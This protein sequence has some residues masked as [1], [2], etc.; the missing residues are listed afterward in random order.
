MKS[1]SS[2]DVAK[3][4]VRVSMTSSRQEEEQLIKDLNRQGIQVTAVDIGGNLI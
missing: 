2:L 1:F 4:A 3:A